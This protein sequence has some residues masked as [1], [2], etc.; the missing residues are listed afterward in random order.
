DLDLVKEARPGDVKF[1]QDG[2]GILMDPMSV[3]YLK[4][5]QIDYVEDGM[6]A[7]FAFK[8]PNAKASC[9]CGSSFSA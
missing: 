8:N 2:V 9:G 6:R 4:G 1:E 3:Q 5:T 7:G